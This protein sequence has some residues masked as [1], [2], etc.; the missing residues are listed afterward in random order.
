MPPCIRAP[1]VKSHAVCAPQAGHAPRSLTQSAPKTDPEE[2]LGDDGTRRRSADFT[3]CGGGR[4][5]PACEDLRDRR[6]DADE[7][8]HDQAMQE[9]LVA[10]GIEA[11]SD[12]RDDH[13]AP[14]RLGA[15]EENRMCGGEESDEHASS[16]G[17]YSCANPGAPGDHFRGWEG[18]RRIGPR[19]TEPPDAPLREH[20][21]SDRRRQ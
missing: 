3:V 8:A 2:A 17:A 16:D 18:R 21:L 9:Q 7:R 15:I 6:V 12:K 14:R 4:G 19:D 11:C 13:C 20:R 5:E 1:V 10:H